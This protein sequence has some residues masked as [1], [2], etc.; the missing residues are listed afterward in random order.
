MEQHLTS[1]LQTPIIIHAAIADCGLWSMV[2]PKG[3]VTGHQ[4]IQLYYYCR[5]LD[6]KGSGWA[7]V[8]VKTAAAILQ[9]SIVSIR[10]RI[11]CG[12][13]LG[14]F[15]GCLKLT[16]GCYRVFYRSLVKVA[17]LL[18]VEDLG[19]ITKIDISEIKDIKFKATEAQALLLQKRSRYRQTHR[20][21][22]DR[23][24][25]AEPNE[26]VNS[27]LR[28][29]SILTRYG[30]VVVLRRSHAAYGG[31]QF[32]LGWLMGRHQSTI[33]RRLSNGYRESHGLP[34]VP[35]VQLATEPEM[36]IQTLPNGRPPIRRK[37][38][39]QNLIKIPGLGTFRLRCNVYA[40]P[41]ELLAKRNL[42]AKVRREIQ[43]AT[44]REIFGNDWKFEP[45]YLAYK[46]A[47]RE[48]NDKFKLSTVPNAPP[49][50][51]KDIP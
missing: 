3:Q 27:D 30:R 26:L 46:A 12:L 38:P 37:T 25:T 23:R 5:A 19:A 8:E 13:S 7:D 18:G 20:K 40:L 1:I 36:M 28:N 43:R 33:Q 49:L 41:Y 11:K 47:L 14:L 44:D 24:R 6:I 9:T 4:A 10:R 35:K 17:A 29:G 31:S 2:S 48:Q 39:G 15:T 16:P 50:R 34:P 45:E 22:C 32:R 51:S 42:R 21:K